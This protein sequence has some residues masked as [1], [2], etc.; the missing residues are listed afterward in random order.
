MTTL[1]AFDRSSKYW[2]FTG[3]VNQQLD[4]ISG[5]PIPLRNATN[6]K[7]IPEKAG[8]QRYFKD[9]AWHYVVDNTGT[10]YWLADGSKH[11]IT[12]LG[13]ELPEG[14]LLEEPPKPEPTFEERLASTTAQRAAAYKSESDPLY[15][16]WQYDDTAEAKQKWR[17]K[18]A[19]IKKRLPLP[20]E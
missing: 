7:L 12:E 13:E 2:L 18:V 10:E 15:M 11:T 3:L 6:V 20:T 1:Y 8:H 5:E 14:A 19:E 17:D 16:E 9:G 4:A